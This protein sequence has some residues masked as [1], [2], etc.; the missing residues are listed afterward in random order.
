MLHVHTRQVDPQLVGKSTVSVLQAKRGGWQAVHLEA[1]VTASQSTLSSCTQVPRLS[2]QSRRHPEWC[3]HLEAAVQGNEQLILDAR[4]PGL[5]SGSRV[6]QVAILKRC[7]RGVPHVRREDLQAG[8]LLLHV[9][10]WREGGLWRTAQWRTGQ[11][12]ALT[13]EQ[14]GRGAMQRAQQDGG[15][16]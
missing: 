6:V 7:Q 9:G 13:A 1:A 8:L 14:G 11:L 15:L 2:L 5:L 12:Q 16:P 3:T 10:T 4:H